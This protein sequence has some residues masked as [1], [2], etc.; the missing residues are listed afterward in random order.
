MV[1]VLRNTELV[2]F[3]PLLLGIGKNFYQ[4]IISEKVYERNVFITVDILIHVECI[5]I[6]FFRRVAALQLDC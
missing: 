1:F 2:S 4:L 5:L 3:C 6:D